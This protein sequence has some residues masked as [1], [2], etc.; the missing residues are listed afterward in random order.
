MGFF[1]RIT[2]MIIAMASVVFVIYKLNTKGID[3]AIFHMEPGQTSSFNPSDVTHFEWKSINKIFSYDKDSAG[4]WLPKKNEAALKNLF[5]FLSQI[6]LSQVEQKGSSSLDVVLDIKGERWTG[7]WDGLSFVWKTGPNASKGE[8]LSEQKNM[9]FF[10]GAHIFDTVQINLCKNRVT[11]LFVQT[12]GKNYQIEQAGRGWQVVAPEK[13]TL[14][15][16]FIEKWLIGLC[17]VKVKTILDLAYAQSNTRQGA[18]TFEFV[19]GEKLSLF[20]VEKDFFV[21]DNLGLVLDHLGSSLETL[22]K[23]LQP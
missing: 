17:D 19:N 7:S 15:P 11:K 16:I 22:K 9:V 20:Q 21:S 10:K 23:Q 8:I 18:I 14:D 1:V 2:V 13:K 12:N 6:Q 5:S 4:G 3:P